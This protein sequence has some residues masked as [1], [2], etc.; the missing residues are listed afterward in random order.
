MI[1]VEAND[2]PDFF[3]SHGGTIQALLGIDS[4]HLDTIFYYAR[5][6]FNSGDYVRAK[7]YCHILTKLSHWQYEYWLL[8]GDVC[9][10]LNEY[11]EA[12]LSF[13]QAGLLRLSSPYPPYQTGL[14]HLMTGSNEAQKCFQAAL[15]RCGDNDEFRTLREFIEKHFIPRQDSNNE[16]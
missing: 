9:T 11:E 16:S 7:K 6:L 3:F 12:L 8:Y 10:K 13:Q 5:L 14:I 2:L 4:K 15:V 1:E